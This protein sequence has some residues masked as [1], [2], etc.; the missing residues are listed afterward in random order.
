MDVETSS[1]LN[2]YRL[3]IFT[4]TDASLRLLDDLLSRLRIPRTML[5]R[6]RRTFSLETWFM[7][8]VLAGTIESGT[9]ILRSRY[10]VEIDFT[11]SYFFEAFIKMMILFL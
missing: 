10:T 4:A 8:I 6:F 2:A 11:I 7:K 1:R 3:A 9:T 5:I